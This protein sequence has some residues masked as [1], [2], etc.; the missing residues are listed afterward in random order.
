MKGEGSSKIS[1]LDR[2][3]RPELGLR[4]D[5]TVLFLEFATEKDAIS[6][7]HWLV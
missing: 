4:S 2:V 3:S 5:D 7:I 1:G 6:A